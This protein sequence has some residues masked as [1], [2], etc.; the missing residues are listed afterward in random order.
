MRRSLFALVMLG[1]C[2]GPAPARP[3]GRE[4]SASALVDE[5]RA[6]VEKSTGLTFKN[7]IK[8]VMRSREEVRQYLLDKLQQEFPPSRQAGLEAEYKLLGMI[9]DSTNL[10]QL[11]LDVLT[12]QVAGYYDPET[13]TLVGVSG[14]SAD[15]LRLVFSHELVHAL[16]HQYLPLDSLMHIRTNADQQ[17][18][19]Q[20]ILEGHATYGSLIYLAPDKSI[21]RQPGFWEMAREQVRSATASMPEFAKA[22]MVIREGLVFPYLN[23]AEFMRWW[24]SAHA[25]RPLPTLAEMPQSTE[26]ILHPDRYARHDNPVPVRFAAADDSVLYEDTMGEFELQL[27]DVVTRGGREDA[28]D[29][30]P[31]GWGGDRFRVYQTPDG[32]ALVW[33]IVWD[34]SQSAQ[35]FLRGTGGLLER[36]EKAGYR[37]MVEAIER[38]GPATTRV[39]IAPLNWR[40]WGSPPE[41]Q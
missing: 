23:G 7:P 18:A 17:A 1:A 9:P 33:Y 38:A 4:P 36:K 29:A 25:D 3:T 31:I 13:S 6:G 15:S 24:D 40:R 11:L 16:Q 5:L 14:A 28:Q 39:M 27:L 26:Q 41:L 10:R 22:P 8:S 37:T 20:A 35:R 30:A 19:A 2:R 34:D 21:I 32:P 12:E